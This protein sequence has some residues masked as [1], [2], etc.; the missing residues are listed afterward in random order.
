MSKSWVDPGDNVYDSEILINAVIRRAFSF[1]LK[2]CMDVWEKLI[3]YFIY[4]TI[5]N[6]AVT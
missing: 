2:T 6:H 1:F 4:P 5:Q 3:V